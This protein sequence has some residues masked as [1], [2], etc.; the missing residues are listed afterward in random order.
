MKYL[1]LQG[2]H[3]KI[4]DITIQTIG[5][6][7]NLSSGQAFPIFFHSIQHHMSSQYIEIDLTI[8]DTLGS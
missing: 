5:D 6:L 3:S 8:Q 7:I 2:L 4:L 1:S